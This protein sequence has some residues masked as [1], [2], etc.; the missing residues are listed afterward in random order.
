MAIFF[1]GFCSRISSVDEGGLL[2]SSAPPG[3]V[4]FAHSFAASVF[5]TWW[6]VEGKGMRGIL[7]MGLRFLVDMFFGDEAGLA[8]MERNWPF[9]DPVPQKE[10]RRPPKC[11]CF[12]YGVSQVE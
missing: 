4:L 10:S 11:F 1:I 9:G 5:G 8:A 2:L 3:F 12:V 6:R 7:F